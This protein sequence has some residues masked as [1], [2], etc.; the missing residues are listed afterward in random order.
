MSKIKKC[1]NC[2]KKKLIKLFSLGKLH[3][4]GKFEKDGRKIKSGYLTLVICKHC[5]LVQLDRNFNLK[6]LYNK[7]YG[8]M[9]GINQTMR[10]HL[11]N[12][13]E[14]AKKK[15]ELKNGDNVLDVASNDGTLLNYYPKKRVVTVGVDPVLNKFKSNYNNINYSFAKFFDLRILKHKIFKK[16]FKIIS[17]LSVFYDL[18]NPNKFL[19]D[20]SKVLHPEGV[21]ILEFAD[22][23]SIIKNNIFDT[24][25]HEHLEYYSVFVI[26]KMLK[27][28]GLKIID[29]KTNK[30]NG[31]SS[32]FF[33]SFENLKKKN[34]E[35]KISK[36]IAKEIKLGLNNPRFYKKFFNNILKIGRTI[37]IKL[38]NEIDNKKII[39][40]YGASTKGNVLIE[41][42]KLKKYLKYICDRNPKKVGL[43]T[44]G[45]NIKIISEKRSRSLKPDYYFVLPWHFKKEILLREKKIRKTGTKFIFPLPK[46]KIH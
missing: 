33:I 31:G 28:H 15:V 29:Y 38:D 39:H 43:R 9:S 17:A 12:V 21:F 22:L 7:D 6:Y 42:F 36:I 10:N 24:I 45:T 11:K 25:C 44:P 26:K 18:E 8:Y 1:R 4:T 3:F 41:F 34:L 13:V 20:V 35:N 16:K 40:G 37:K 27:K 32:L 19:R 14:V 30:I 2:K 23:K 5:K 46:L